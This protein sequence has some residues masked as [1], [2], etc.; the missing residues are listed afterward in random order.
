MFTQLQT[1][2]R[3]IISY[4]T[5]IIVLLSYNVFGLCYSYTKLNDIVDHCFP[6]LLED[7]QGSGKIQSGNFHGPEQFSTFTYW[8][9]S[10]PNIDG[11]VEHLLKASSSPKKSKELKVKDSKE[12]KAA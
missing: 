1:E 10:L 6:P 4:S 9:D 8:R 11:E 3:R 12:T 7:N 2:F 5:Q